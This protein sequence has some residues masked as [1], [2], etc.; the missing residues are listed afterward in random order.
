M[1]RSSRTHKSKDFLRR[2][3]SSMSFLLP[4][5]LNKMVY[6]RGRI[7][8]FWIWQ[9][10]C[11]MN[12]R[13]RICFGRRQLTPLATPSID[14]TFTESSRKHHI[15]SSLVKIPMF[16]ILEFLGANALFLLKEV[17]I[18]NLLLKH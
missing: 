4:T 16:L 5:H 2:R 15:N 13:L 14:S 8:L 17:E 11:L 10:P 9:E 7:E 6:W 18:L 3:A 12:T 1:A